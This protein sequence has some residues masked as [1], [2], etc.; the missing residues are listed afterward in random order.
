M[1]DML[2]RDVPDSVIAEIDAQAA[3]L[4]VSR[5]EFVRRQLL[6]EAQRA[7]QAV[8]VDDLKRSSHLMRDL[9]DEDLMDQAWR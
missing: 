7:K 3:R 2:I 6:R 8:T 4:G 1:T 9:L 5:A